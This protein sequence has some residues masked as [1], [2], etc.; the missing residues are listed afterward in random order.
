MWTDGERCGRGTVSAAPTAAHPQR[1]TRLHALFAPNFAVR[2]CATRPHR[3]VRVAG[4]MRASRHDSARRR[5]AVR[6]AGAGC[7]APP[8]STVTR[9]AHQLAHIA[10][11]RMR[12]Q[13]TSTVRCV[14]RPFPF[15]LVEVAVRRQSGVAK[16]QRTKRGAGCANAAQRERRKAQLQWHQHNLIQMIMHAMTA[17]WHKNGRDV[18]LKKF[19][20]GAK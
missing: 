11:P 12:R 8:A 14:W 9:C 2:Q 5:R 20:N 4:C 18:S 10:P 3:A 19:S 6:G 17:V 1:T 7:A 15:L 13:C 16:R